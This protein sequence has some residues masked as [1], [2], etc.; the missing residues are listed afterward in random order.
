MT[1]ELVD[2]IRRVCEPNE[3]LNAETGK[4]EIIRKHGHYRVQETFLTPEGRILFLAYNAYASEPFAVGIYGLDLA[5]YWTDGNDARR[6]LAWRI[7][8]SF[9]LTVDKEGSKAI[10]PASQKYATDLVKEIKQAHDQWYDLPDDIE[11]YAAG[12][13]VADHAISLAK[14]LQ[15]IGVLS[16]PVFQDHEVVG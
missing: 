15:R 7:A 14:F 8:E 16:A 10:V 3:Y 1:Y 5:I 11:A 13:Q 12:D 6:H 9:G 2:P 4:Y